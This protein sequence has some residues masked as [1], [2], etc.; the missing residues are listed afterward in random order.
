M[1]GLILRVLSCK[2][3]LEAYLSG[4]IEKIEELE[5]DILPYYDGALQ[6]NFYRNNI[7]TSEL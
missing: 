1:G 2:E 5:E 4:K 3:K 6:M 7:T